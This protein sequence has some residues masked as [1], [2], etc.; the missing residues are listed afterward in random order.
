MEQPDLSEVLKMHK[1]FGI[2]ASNHAWDIASKENPTEEDYEE[3]LMAAYAAGYHW[4]K[5]EEDINSI[6]IDMLLAHVHAHLR[7]SEMSLKHANKCLD[8][9]LNHES[10]PWDV[11]FSYAEMAYACAVSGE[12]K[13]CEINIEH[14]K[15]EAERIPDPDEKNIFLDELESIQ[16]EIDKVSV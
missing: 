13:D 1:W 16:H 3:M 8:Y 12:Q 5:T 6:R 4:S 10:R 14:A 11:A 7:N 15:D 9:C 2:Q